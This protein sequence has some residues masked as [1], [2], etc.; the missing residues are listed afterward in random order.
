MKLYSWFS[1][2]RVGHDSKEK[3]RKQGAVGTFVSGTPMGQVT[4]IK[5][6]PGPLPLL[7]GMKKTTASVAIE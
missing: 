3:E 2:R 5:S 6:Q 4:G 7:P 1:T